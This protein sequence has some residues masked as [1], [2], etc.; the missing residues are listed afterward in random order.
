MVPP[1]INALSREYYKERWK[2]SSFPVLKLT[3]WKEKNGLVLPTKMFFVDGSTIYSNK[4]DADVRRLFNYDYYLGSKIESK[5]KL[6]DNK[7][8]I[9]SRP[10]GRWF[11]EYPTPYLIKRGIYHNW[12]I[13]DSLK[14]N[15]TKIL[16]QLIPLLLLIKKGSPEL[17]RENIKA[18]Y[19]DE[20]LKEVKNRIQ[21]LMD[22]VRSNKV[23]DKTIK[24]PTRVTNFDEELKYLIPDIKSMFD[25][26]L[27]AVP[28][29]NILSAL[30]F[31]DVIEA[32]STSRRESILNPKAFIEETKSG[33]RGFKEV[34]Q[35]VMYRIKEENSSH[36]KYMNVEY[37]I[38]HSPVTAFATDDF[39]EK[40]RQLYD[41]GRIS[42]QTACELIAEVDFETEVI[43]K[44]REAERGI[45]ETMYPPI[46]QNREGEGI[47][48]PADF[49][50]PDTDEEDIPD[51]KKDEVEKQNYNTSE[52]DKDLEIAP[53]QTTKDLP[54]RVK[55]N[56]S[57]SLQSVFLRVFN[58]A[59]EKYQND[60]KAFRIA[61]GIIKKI[62]KNK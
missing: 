21:E 16:D 37:Y 51:D 26:E 42:S 6:T 5:A 33:V 48:I 36:T 8:V 44:E 39:K 7:D 10:Y 11:D 57:P 22:E 46:T 24:A 59:Y 56:L 38:T 35:Q 41:R 60:S 19:S 12:K 29:R 62:A 18:G 4:K 14:D 53:Y 2:G 13:I 23:D 49:S 27:T 40:V 30:G 25:K 1:G 3:G 17:V 34:L 28:E 32:T 47:D 54:A 20:E 55:K 61:W 9:F 15:Q 58:Q 43:R 52:K 45:E 50:N 31:V